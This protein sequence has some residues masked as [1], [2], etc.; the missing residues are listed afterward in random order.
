MEKAVVNIG[1]K[2]YGLK[3]TIGFWKKIKEACGVDA[4]NIEKKL[5][6][7]FGV[8]APQIVLQGIIGEH[9]QTA[10]LP[11]IEDIE[12][13]LDRSVMDAIEQAII[14]GMTKAEREMVEIVKKQRAAAI[15]GIETKIENVAA[16]NGDDTKK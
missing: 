10:V 12:N 15:K 16:S 13:S 7:D 9:G 5:Q 14:N 11:S 6:E 3:F 8:I 1:D 4:Q 2:E